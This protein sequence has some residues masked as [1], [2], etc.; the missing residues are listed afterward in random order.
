MAV[1]YDALTLELIVSVHIGHPSRGGAQA[2]IEPA[3][4]AEKT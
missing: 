3:V 4:A 1:T 2:G